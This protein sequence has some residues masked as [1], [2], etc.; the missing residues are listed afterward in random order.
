M[1]VVSGVHLVP[2]TRWSRTY[3]IADR[4]LTLVDSGL[5]W[6]PR[7][8]LNY[9]RSIGR[10]P[11][12]LEHILITHSHPDHIG[13]T[14]SL[15][16]A[17]GAGVFAHKSDSRRWKSHG[18]RLSYTGL[19]GG[20]G[21]PLPYLAPVTVDVSVSDGETLPIH[22]GVRVIHTPGHTRGS[23]CFLL[24]RSQTLFSGDTVFSDG[25]RLSRSVP[26]PGYD[27]EDYIRS[28]ERLTEI[29]FEA[30]CGG[31]GWPLSTGGRRA[32]SALIGQHPEPPTWRDFWRSVPRSLRVRL[33][34]TAEQTEYEEKTD[35]PEE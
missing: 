16:R 26:F 10:S 6:D 1:E 25:R 11:E 22:G 8:V 17:T 31:H 33:P 2:S 14:A 15:V 13:G 20:V 3:L 30:V 34:L 9:I 19:L 27:R 5:P 32:L 12:E 24:E 7:G 29:E 4:T 35:G 21:A 18:Q 23:V 28:L